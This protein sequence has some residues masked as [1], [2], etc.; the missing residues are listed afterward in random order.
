M[1]VKAK[2][3]N[4]DDWDTAT[5]RAW[6]RVM[7]VSQPEAARQMGIHSQTVSKYA[8]GRLDV[9]KL[10]VLA[11]QMLLLKRQAALNSAKEQTEKA[12]KRV[13]EKVSKK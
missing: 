3:F 6:L 5:F 9:P 12:I 8:T 11:C 10:T 13:A 2:S 4:N 1:S 7:D